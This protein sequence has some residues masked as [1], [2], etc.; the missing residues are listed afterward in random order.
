MGSIVAGKN[1]IRR[2]LNRNICL[3]GE[4][5]ISF[6]ILDCIISSLEFNVK[7]ERYISSLEFPLLFVYV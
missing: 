6:S 5:E 1:L 2:R 4:G 3:K 7:I